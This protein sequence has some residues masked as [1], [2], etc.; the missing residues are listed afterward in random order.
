MSEILGW[1]MLNVCIGRRDQELGWTTY[2]GCMK[3]RIHY[4]RC[5]K[6]ENRL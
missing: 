1:S 6:R 2:V 3:V 4:E 5:L